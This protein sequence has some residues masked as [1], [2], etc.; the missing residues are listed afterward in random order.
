[1]IMENTKMNKSGIRITEEGSFEQY[2]SI[3]IV[4]KMFEISEKTLRRIIKDREIELIRIGG[5]IRL[6]ESEIPK[7]FEK[8]PSV[9]SI[10]NK[11]IL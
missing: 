7:L 8:E 5:S 1:M 9:V 6:S 3:K 11:F 4:A 10:T 2:Y